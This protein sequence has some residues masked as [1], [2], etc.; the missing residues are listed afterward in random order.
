MAGYTKKYTGGD[1]ELDRTLA[2]YG[3]EYSAA[4]AAGDRK[5]MRD[6]ND[7]ANMARN[8]KGYAAEYAT[9]DILSTPDRTGGGSGGEAQP[10]PIGPAFPTPQLPAMPA[11][12]KT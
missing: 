11:S 12:T 8:E 9:A 1:D 4:K 6:A 3:E 7:R 5:A 10:P 2:Q